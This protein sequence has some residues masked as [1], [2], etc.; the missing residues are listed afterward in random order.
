METSST[1]STPQS[2][3]SADQSPTTSTWKTATDVESPSQL[4]DD[5]NDRSNNESPRE[6]TPT[7]DKAVGGFVSGT[8]RSAV[9]ETLVGGGV[10]GKVVDTVADTVVD[11]I[12]PPEEVGKNI[13][14]AVA[15]AGGLAG[16]S[17]GDDGS[18]NNSTDVTSS[19]NPNKRLLTEDGKKKDQTNPET[20]PRE[21]EQEI[22]QT[23]ATR[24]N[25]HKQTWVGNEKSVLGSILRREP[26]PALDKAVGD[27]VTKTAAKFELSTVVG[28][29]IAAGLGKATDALIDK[30]VPTEEV[31]KNISDAVAATGGI[32]R[33]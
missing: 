12:V 28:G 19:T 32:S 3:S 16:E 7:L 6:S 24:T 15:T 10:A 5:D 30:Y 11:T 23:A 14:D 26:G 27:F 22:E 21:P 2:K 9:V 13:S 33:E 20:S 29:P 4:S 31:G 25:Q 17:E 1:P 18:P 8:A